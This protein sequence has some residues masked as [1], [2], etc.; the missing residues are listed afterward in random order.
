MAFALDLLKRGCRLRK[1]ELIEP[2]ETKQN[3]SGTYAVVVIIV[4]C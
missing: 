3:Q 2:V 4:S 1:T